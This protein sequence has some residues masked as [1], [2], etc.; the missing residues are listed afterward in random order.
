MEENKNEEVV[1][2]MEVLREINGLLSKVEE[3]LDSNVD[4]MD[5]AI[6]ALVGISI[7]SFLTSTQKIIE[8]RLEKDELYQQVKANHIA[9][10]DG[11]SMN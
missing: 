7:H 1:K 3:K 4:N 2:A 6:A 5:T 8:R 11:M 9:N 10:A